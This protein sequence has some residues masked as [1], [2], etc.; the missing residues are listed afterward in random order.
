[1]VKNLPAMQETWLQSLGWK[2]S[3]EK[4]I[5]THSNIL[6]WKIPWTEGPGG[7]QSTESQRAGHFKSLS[8]ARHFVTPWPIRSMHSPGQNTGVGGCSLLQGIFPTQGLNTGLLHC[9]RILNQLSRK[10]SPMRV[11]NFE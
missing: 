3:L 11:V 9:R 10:G 5:T 8:R 6:A 7:L 2:D 4:E 1:M